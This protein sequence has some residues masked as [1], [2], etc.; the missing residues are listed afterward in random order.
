MLP[1]RSIKPGASG[2]DP[3]ARAKSVTRGESGE[4]VSLARVLRA[5]Y[6]RSRRAP[7]TH[8]TLRSIKPG[9]SGVDQRARAKSREEKVERA[10][11]SRASYARSRRAPAMHATIN[12]QHKLR[13]EGLPGVLG[14][15]GTLAKYRR[16][17]GNIS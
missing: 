13:S 14:N 10:C 7:A 16:E 15:N 12:C 6:A 4:S 1:L 11:L 9:A 17:Q 5:F 3:R 2:V 8:A